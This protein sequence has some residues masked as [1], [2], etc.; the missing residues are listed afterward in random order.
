VR[1]LVA[2]GELD[3]VVPQADGIRLAAA[4]PRTASVVLAGTGHLAHLEAH[5]DLLVAL[6][7]LFDIDELESADPLYRRGLDARR[8]VLGEDAVKAALAAITPEN[9]DFQQFVTEYEWGAIWTRPGLD[10]RMRVA[11]ALASLITGGHSDEVTLYVRGA[12]A[13]GLT[14]DE[15]AEILQQT[16]L[17]A[18]LPAANTAFRLA[19][20]VF[21]DIDAAA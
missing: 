10:R 18:G 6:Y 12:L 15:I 1:T 20:A 13:V 5:A 7:D 16:A 19:A 17:Y 14:R 11:V 4:M 9:A 3:V 8:A 2:V 21:A